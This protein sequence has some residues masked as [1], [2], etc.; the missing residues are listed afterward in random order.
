VIFHTAASGGS[1]FKKLTTKMFNTH[2]LNKKA[3]LDDKLSI[4]DT[5]YFSTYKVVDHYFHDW[6][7]VPR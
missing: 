2:V 1:G 7:P 5:W 4:R 6:L 3:Q